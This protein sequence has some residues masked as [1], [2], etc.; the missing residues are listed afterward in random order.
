MNNVTD[1]ILRAWTGGRKTRVSPKGWVHGNAPCCVHNGETKDKR[2]R[3]GFKVDDTTGGI[4][5]HCFNCNFTTGYTPGKK[6]FHKTRKLLGWIGIDEHDIRHLSIEA[7]RIRDLT[8][9]VIEEA[10]EREAVT[11]KERPLPEDALSFTQWIEWYALKEDDNYPQGLIDAV[12][13]A[14]E[15]FG[16]LSKAPDLYWTP[17][18]DKFMNKRLIIPF[19]WKGKNVGYT[20]RKIFDG[21]KIPKY[22]MEVDSDYVYG[23]DRLIEQSEFVFVFEGPTDAILMNGVAVLSNKISPE[24]ADLIEDLNKKVIVV[25]D[26]EASGI[27]LI[28]DAIEYG[29]S[30]SFP[31][32]DEDIKDT[33]EAVQRY[34]KLFTLKSII[35][36]IQSTKLKIKLHMKKLNG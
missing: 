18:K 28:E 21:S 4:V 5:Y 2:S 22:H 24:Q 6:L 30:V 16:D 14:D 8:P 26:L 9:F 35:S 7:L 15:R 27:P 34:G 20:A 3:G 32:W 19:T 36:N 13:Y 17:N 11:F 1:A 25:P 12:E 29:W 33:G 23:T 31:D 10:K